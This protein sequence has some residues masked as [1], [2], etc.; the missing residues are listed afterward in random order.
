MDGGGRS[1]N[2]GEKGV[3]IA[4]VGKGQIAADEMST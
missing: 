3:K 2:D 1:E 4:H